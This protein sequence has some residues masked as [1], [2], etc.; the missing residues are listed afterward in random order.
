MK[1]VSALL[2]SAASAAVL[3]GSGSQTY[4][5][6]DADGNSVVD[7]RDASLILTEYAR[8]SVGKSGT[9]S[10]IQNKAADVD[11]NKIVDGRDASWILSY[12]AYISVNGGDMDLRRFIKGEP[13]E[14][15]TEAPTE[16]FERDYSFE[17]IAHDVE[18]FAHYSRILN[19]ELFQGKGIQ[20]AYGYT[21]CETE[22]E[23][24]LAILNYGQIDDNVLRCAFQYYSESDIK[25]CQNFLYNYLA[26]AH[27]KLGS[28][29]DFTKYTFNK[30][31][32]EYLNSIEQAADNGTLLNM[33]DDAWNND[34]M[35]ED[36]LNHPAPYLALESY[37]SE[38]DMN[39]IINPGGADNY[40]VRQMVN[41]IINKA[42]GK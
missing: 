9:F 5:L 10:D 2:L 15:I 39:Q 36:C 24:L 7:G 30:T 1:K 11:E 6:G 21:G 40:I 23:L 31:I 29:V 12:Y 17:N 4:T 27:K 35:P 22:C 41:D 13:T 32:G 20:C 25:N 33:I 14:P 37:D 42:L 16:Y 3:C 8:T 19:G 18:V 26:Y 38:Y 28:N 34:N